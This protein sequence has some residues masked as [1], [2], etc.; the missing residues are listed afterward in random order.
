MKQKAK[1]KKY[2]EPLNIRK[3]ARLLPGYIVLTL[4]VLF[5]AALLS[6]IVAASFST[7]KEIFS[8]QMLQSG[9]HFEN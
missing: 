4:W 9:L 8:N 1:K 6:W 7:T 2:M 3:E 5:T